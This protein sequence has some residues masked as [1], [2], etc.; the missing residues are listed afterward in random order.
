M[1][2]NDFRIYLYIALFSLNGLH[3]LFPGYFGSRE[4]LT[5]WIQSQCLVDFW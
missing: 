4:I 2:C 1:N 3:Y 5:V